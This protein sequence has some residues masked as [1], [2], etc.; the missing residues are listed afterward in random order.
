MSIDENGQRYGVEVGSEIAVETSSGDVAVRGVAGNQVRVLASDDGARITEVAGGLAI[1]SGHGGSHDLRLE[2]PGGCAL[3]VRT[4][5]GDIV[6]SNLENGLNVQT[7]SGDVTAEQVAGRLAI[8]AVSGDVNVAS[9][10]SETFN[11]E[12]VSG[13]TIMVVPLS[14]QGEYAVRS[15]SGDLSLRVPADQRCTLAVR[16][17]SGDV[18]CDLPHEMA[19]QGWGKR[20][21]A[22]NGGGVILS[23]HTTSGDV[24]LRAMEGAV[25]DDRPTAKPED[26]PQ[27]PWSEPTSETHPLDAGGD[28]EPFGLD[29]G[30]DEAEA[31]LS[32]AARRMA[33]L[34]A[35]EEGRLSVGE[36]LEKL[37]EFE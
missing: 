13:D 27:V 2:I 32:P 25:R 16:S 9:P 26:E 6:V 30:G 22:V 28:D 10:R 18:R 36:G 19:G 35:I 37:R 12:T 34:K 29:A 24:R 5:S 14:G 20:D 31:A 4:V 11:I 3:R 8:H 21:V 15:V 33:V 17:L 7:M 1:R 23:V